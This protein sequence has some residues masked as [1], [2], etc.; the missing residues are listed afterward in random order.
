[1]VSACVHQKMRIKI[2]ITV[3]IDDLAVVMPVKYIGA[4]DVEY[5]TIGSANIAAH[6][7]G[8]VKQLAEL[9]VVVIGYVQAVENT[10]RE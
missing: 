2:G 6:S 1:M 10:H 8:N 9:L 5:R 3:F 4:Y 7:N